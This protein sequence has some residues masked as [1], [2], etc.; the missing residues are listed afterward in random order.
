MTFCLM[1]TM[2]R[3]CWICNAHMSVGS[4]FLGSCADAACCLAQRRCDCQ[5]NCGMCVCVVCFA[6]GPKGQG[7]LSQAIVIWS[8]AGMVGVLGIASVTGSKRRN[9]IQMTVGKC[10]A[11][12]IM[13]FLCLSGIWIPIVLCEIVWESHESFPLDRGY[14]GPFPILLSGQ[15]L[16]FVLPWW[17][18][19][20]VRFPPLPSGLVNV[21]VLRW[22][23]ACVCWCLCCEA[24][25]YASL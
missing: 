18:L 21:R 17:E 9:M 20:V 4:M 10:H 2:S 23:S 12:P 8:I 1:V 11:L 13:M 5:S 19:F 6:G 14:G 24:V 16:W 15:V 25:E 3:S 7:L 22:W